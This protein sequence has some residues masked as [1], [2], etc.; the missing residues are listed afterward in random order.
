MSDDKKLQTSKKL[1]K[2]LKQVE[3]TDEWNKKISL[4]LQKRTP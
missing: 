4:T 1:S 2:S 3:H